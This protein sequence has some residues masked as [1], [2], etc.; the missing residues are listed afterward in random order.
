MR[1]ALA[2]LGLL[3]APVGAAA[4][5]GLDVVAGKALFERNWVSAPAST[6][7]ADGLGPLFNAKSCNSCH[8]DGGAARFTSLDGK[9]VARGLVV[10]LARQ[11]GLPHPMFGRQLQDHA[12][13]GLKPEGEINVSL[14][15]VELFVDAQLFGTTRDDVIKEV[16]IAPSLRGRGMLER[17]EE[18]A[19]LALADPEDADGD[20]ISGR[21]RL[22]E[23][24]AH[25]KSLGRFGSKAT[26]QSL[27]QQTA[28]A[29]AFDIGLSSK[30]RPL[31][32]G[33]CTA[34]QPECL[35]MATGQSVAF[36]GDEIPQG[37]ITLM[38]GYVRSLAVK[39]RVSSAPGLHLFVSMGC[40]VCHRPEMPD[41]AGNA[42]PV[43]TDLLLHDLGSQAAGAIPDQGFSPSEWRTAPLIDLDPMGGKRRY[44]HDGRAATVS[45]AIEYHGGEATQAQQAFRR[46]DGRER[47]MLINYLSGL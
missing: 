20:G 5:D 3:V 17:I 42:L 34:E 11:D 16:R 22:I 2:I 25:K 46:M 41:R 8:K 7:A 37:V 24:G 10:R 33:D 38:S 31:A 15:N 19:V 27:E 21:A 28:D 36:G 29:A 6:D 26:A 43:F 45:E 4:A 14:S 9:L 39:M 40:A 13:P 18:N 47:D 30:L 12:V 23:D 44:L 32:H 35:T 1:K